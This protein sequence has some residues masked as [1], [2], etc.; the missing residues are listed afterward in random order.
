MKLKHHY[1]GWRPSLP[2][3]RDVKAD[4]TGLKALP[5]VD[6]RADMPTI[7]D[8][9]Q[10]GSCTANATSTCVEY[11]MHEFLMLPY[12]LHRPSRLFIYY[13]ERM[14]EGTLGQ[15]DTGAYGR[16]GLKFT[17]QY[18]WVPESEWPYHISAFQKKPPQSVWDAA[19]ANRLIQMTY[20]AV[21]RDVDAIKAAL[22]NKQTM[23]F[24]FSVYDSFESDQTL[25]TGYVPMPKRSEGQLGGHE[26]LAVGYL[27]SEPDYCLVRNSWGTT[28]N[29]GPLYG[30]IPGGTTHPGYFLMP[31]DYL[32]SSD[33]SS[34]FRTIPIPA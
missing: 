25:T 27:E 8:Q 28:F 30:G 5:E 14:L 19:K 18:G 15:G 11:W 4:T 21:D 16:D 17:Q 33:L 29:G 32:M 13:G 26:V 10:L 9:G 2:D 34:D 6:P 12:K 22:S 31:W 23:M 1:G 7:L 3:H 24:G 20:K